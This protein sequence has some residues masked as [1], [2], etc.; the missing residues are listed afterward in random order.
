MKVCVVDERSEIAACH[1]GVPQ[2]ALGVRTDVLCGCAKPAGIQMLLR[3]M[4]PQVIAVDELGGE[5]DFLAVERAVYS[6]CP[7]ARHGSRGKRGGAL[8]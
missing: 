8:A 2:N 1:I 7:G 4:S 6:G 3:A 5:E